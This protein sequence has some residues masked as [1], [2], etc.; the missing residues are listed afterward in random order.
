ML[1]KSCFALL[2]VI[3]AHCLG[4]GYKI[5]YVSELLDAMPV[6]QKIDEK[7]LFE[8]LSMLSRGEFISVKYQ[9]DNEVCL[10]P[11]EKGRSV[12]ENKIEERI[13]NTR[14]Q[15]RYFLSAF[16]GA[17]IGAVVGGTLTVA[18]ACVFGGI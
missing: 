17:V 2:D 6:G 1:D 8:C 18:V 4:L 3:N 5:F 15:K 16:L 13:E 11:L 9:D 7:R 14:L 10:C 12:F